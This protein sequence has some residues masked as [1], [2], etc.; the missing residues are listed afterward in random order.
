MKSVEKAVLHR[1][2][3]SAGKLSVLQTLYNFRY[4]AL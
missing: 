3:D 4:A 2:Q 1:M